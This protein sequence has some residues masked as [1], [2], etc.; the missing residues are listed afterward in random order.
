MNVSYIL[1]LPIY[2]QRYQIGKFY[3]HIEFFISTFGFIIN[4]YIYVRGYPNSLKKQQNILIYICIGM[5]ESNKISFSRYF[6]K[7]LHI[8]GICDM[9]YDRLC[10]TD[11]ILNFL[12]S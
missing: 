7:N 5:T 12:P 2:L 11:Q 3:V 8:E 6:H 10:F 1:F 4:I 9:S